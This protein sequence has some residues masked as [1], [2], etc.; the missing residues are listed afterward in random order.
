MEP[1]EGITTEA[2]EITETSFPPFAPLSLWC[3]RPPLPVCCTP[4][5][6]LLLLTCPVFH[7][8]PEPSCQGSSPR[9]SSPCPSRRRR[10]PPNASTTKSTPESVTKGASA[11][12]SCGR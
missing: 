1:T 5:I 10:R 3:Y 11:R 6:L 9:S 4:Y 12:R 2:T 7:L 8:V